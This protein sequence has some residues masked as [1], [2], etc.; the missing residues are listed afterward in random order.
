M[1]EVYCLKVTDLSSSTISIEYDGRIKEV[2]N[3]GTAP[4]GFTELGH[5][6]DDLTGTLKWVPVPI[7]PD[8]QFQYLLRKRCEEKVIDQQFCKNP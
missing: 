2:I 3:E 4:G 8:P 5:Q 6:I 7:L 1:R